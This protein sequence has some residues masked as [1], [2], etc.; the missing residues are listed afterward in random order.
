M[1]ETIDKIIFTKPNQAWLIHSEDLETVQD[2][3]CNLYAII[4]AYSQ[5][6]FTQLVHQD[7]PS[8][9]EFKKLFKEAKQK[10]SSFPDQILISAKDPSGD[11]LRLIC[12]ELKIRLEKINSNEFQPLVADFSQAI[13]RFQGHVNEELLGSRP[14]SE[15]IAEA[16]SLVPEPYDPCPCASGKKFKFCCKPAFKAIVFAMNAANEERDCEK[17]LKFMDEASIAV[18]LTAEVLC[19]YGIVWSFFDKEKSKNFLKEALIAN[20]NHPR[21]NYIMG[22]ESVAEGKFQ[23]AVVFYERAIAN[24]PDV[25]RYHLNE[26]YNNLGTA[27]YNLGNIVAAKSSWERGLLYLPSDKMTLQNLAEFIY[28][29]VTL[30]EPLRRMSPEVKRV[31]RM[32]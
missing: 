28:D 20:P 27:Y 4:D 3:H 10:A 13:K 5:H 15:E 1:T 7:L 11:T 2:G 22:I 12:D 29:D 19:R 32:G 30:P 14:T 24:Y 8:A 21:S 31:L 25:D 16:R 9:A 17:A 18:G 26:T 6:C 23:E